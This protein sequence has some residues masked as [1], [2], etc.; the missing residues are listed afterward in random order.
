[1][2]GS[3]IERSLAIPFNRRESRRVV[4]TCAKSSRVGVRGVPRPLGIQFH[5]GGF[6]LARISSCAS[7]AASNWGLMIR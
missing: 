3:A 4:A 5:D 6:S 1:V 2:D 7:S